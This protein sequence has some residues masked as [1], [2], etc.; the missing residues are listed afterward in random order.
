MNEPF[1]IF[2]FS[3]VQVYNVERR[4]RSHINMVYK[5]LVAWTRRVRLDVGFFNTMYSMIAVAKDNPYLGIFR[6]WLQDMIMPFIKRT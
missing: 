5:C 2:F 3:I 6:T 4:T 1:F